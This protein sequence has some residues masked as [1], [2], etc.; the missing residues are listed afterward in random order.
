MPLVTR[1]CS[2]AMFLL[3]AWR[4]EAVGEKAWRV[5]EQTG[6]QK[7]PMEPTLV[8]WGQR[9]L[10]SQPS[11]DAQCSSEDLECVGKL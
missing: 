2:R 1:G 3:W 4:R 9:E 7:G 11:C 6:P 8:H 5:E 10:H